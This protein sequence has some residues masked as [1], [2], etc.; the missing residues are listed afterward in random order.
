MRDVKLLYEKR[1]GEEEFAKIDMKQ[2][3]KRVFSMY[4]GERHRVTL[5][6]TNDLINAVYDRFGK[7]GDTFYHVENNNHFTITADIE[8]SPQFY[9]WLCGF[10]NKVKIMNPAK[11]KVEFKA[12]L[13]KILG[14]YRDD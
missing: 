2:Y 4:S 6:F 13:S 5:R 9:G 8:T 12:Y 11:V 10:G 3:T 7:D 1:E 14:L